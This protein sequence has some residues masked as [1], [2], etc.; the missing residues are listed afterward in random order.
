MLLGD[1]PTA[2]RRALAAR[3]TVMS[4]SL[5]EARISSRQLAPALAVPSRVTPASLRRWAADLE[6]AAD[7]PRRGRYGRA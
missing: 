1:H 5:K 2:R 6:A 7:T 4:E 3:L